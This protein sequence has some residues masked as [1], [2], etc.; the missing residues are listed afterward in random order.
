MLTR[1]IVV[2]ISQYIQMLNNY[3]VYLKQIQCCMSIFFQL[4]E[5]QV[6]EEKRED[7]KRINE[8][9]RN[10]KYNT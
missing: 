7:M 8:T 9:I 1:F 3:V 2:I 6:N 5:F 10:K 4:R